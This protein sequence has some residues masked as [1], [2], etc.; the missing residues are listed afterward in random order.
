MERF[1]V[2]G[3]KQNESIRFYQGCQMV[4]FQTKNPNLGKFWRALDWKM[5]VYFMAIWKCCVN[6]V[7]IFSLVLVYCVKKNLA[8]LFLRVPDHG[9]IFLQRQGEEGRTADLERGGLGGDVVHG[10]GHPLVL[11]D[12]PGA[13]DLVEQLSPEEWKN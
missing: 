5:L 6:L 7:Y 9:G 1:D 11:A 4:C 12:G 2:F 13:G 8:T 10:P 3:K